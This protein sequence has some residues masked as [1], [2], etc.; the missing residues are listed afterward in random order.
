MFKIWGDLINPEKTDRD[1]LDWLKLASFVVAVL[2]TCVIAYCVV[3]NV[4]K[5][6]GNKVQLL[7]YTLLVYLAC[8][9]VLAIGK[10]WSQASQENTKVKADA[11]LQK[12]KAESAPPPPLLPVPAEAKKP[13]SP[14]TPTTSGANQEGSKEASKS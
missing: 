14:P 1:L 11:D 8:A 5:D 7:L 12:K 6:D 9:G 3:Q 2:W 4:I 10:I 13:D